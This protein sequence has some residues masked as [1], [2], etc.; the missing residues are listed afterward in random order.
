MNKCWTIIDAQYGS[1]GKGLLAGY[2]ANRR[3][4]DTVICAWSPNAGHTFINSN[5]RKFIHCMIPNGIVSPQLKRVLIGPGALIDSE[6]MLQELSSVEDCMKDVTFA[7]HEHAGVCLP[8]HAQQERYDGL[9]KIGSTTKGVMTAQ[10]DRMRR[11]PENPMIAKVQLINTPLEKYV[12]SRQRYIELLQ[13]AYNVQI[14]GAQ[15]FSLSIYHGHYPYV[16]SRDVTVH[17]VLADCGIP[18]DWAMR[19]EVIATLRTYPIRVNNRDGTSGPGY[20]DQYE[21]RKSTV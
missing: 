10:F 6:G 16:T 13:A 15:G 3:Q 19:N 14:E 9:S 17:Q 1:T 11:N 18:N 5:G 21:D 4:P 20:P 12:V 7:I 8:R 2:L